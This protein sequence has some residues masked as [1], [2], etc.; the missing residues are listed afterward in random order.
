MHNISKTPNKKLYIIYILMNKDIMKLAERDKLLQQIQSEIKLQQ[1]NL[2]RQTQELEENHKSN[3]FLE[4]VVEDYKSFRNH[5]IE[6][7]RNQKIFLEGLITYLEKMQVQGK[8]TDR[9]MNQSKHEEKSILDKLDKVK[10][11]LNEL[12]NVT[13]K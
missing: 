8:M 12:I 7:K 2:L 4:G 9:L 13:K 1:M 11:E 5:I 3:K 6:E 10:K